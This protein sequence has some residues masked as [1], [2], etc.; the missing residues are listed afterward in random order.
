MIQIRIRH[1]HASETEDMLVKQN[2]AGRA[3]TAGAS[4][5]KEDKGRP[6][7]CVRRSSSSAL[8]GLVGYH[9]S[10]GIGSGQGA[11]RLRFRDTQDLSA[12]GREVGEGF[13]PSLSG[14][15]WPDYGAS[16][17]PCTHATRLITWA[18]MAATER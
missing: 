6:P 3:L 4:H 17:S 11:C 1:T 7:R 16:T 5:M 18:H 9:S 14:T 13:C 15:G 8:Q 2:S 10:G 12:D